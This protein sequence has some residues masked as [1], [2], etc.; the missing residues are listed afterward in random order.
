MPEAYLDALM[1]DENMDESTFFALNGCPY[2]FMKVMWQLAKLAA[3]YKQTL[4]EH[5]SFDVQQVDDLAECLNGWINNN[6]MSIEEIQ[7]SNEDT[8]DKL[9]RFHCVEAWRYAIILYS[10]RVF[11]LHQDSGDLRVIDHLTR[12]ILDHV[13][14]IRETQMVQK[15]VLLPVFLAGVEVEDDYSRF[16]VRQYCNRWSKTARYSQFETALALIE[17]IWAT[18]DASQRAVYWWGCKIGDYACSEEYDHGGYGIERE[19]LLG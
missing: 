18:C 19:L 4:L 11:R 5:G 15:Q 12:V 6:A 13:R 10:R 7:A 14:C 16:F 17:N 8:N 9:D 2:L 1:V 3:N